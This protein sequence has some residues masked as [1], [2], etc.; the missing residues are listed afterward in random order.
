MKFYFLLY[1]NR[2]LG[3]KVYPLNNL[4]VILGFGLVM[5][6]LFLILVIFILSNVLAFFHR[7]K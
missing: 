4:F 3:R 6:E 1:L 5:R 2:L 7:V